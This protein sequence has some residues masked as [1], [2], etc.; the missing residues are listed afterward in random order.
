MIMG[1]FSNGSEGMDYELNYCDKCVHQNP[2]CA[3][4]EAHVLRN[5]EDCNRPE[6]ILHMLIPRSKDG[7]SNEQ[8]R[9]F[10]P[11]P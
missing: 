1:Y 6:S 11:N 5:Y 9:M 10:I 3:V 7:L 4:W 2:H 8:C